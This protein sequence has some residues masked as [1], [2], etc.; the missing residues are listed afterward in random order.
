MWELFFDFFCSFLCRLNPLRY[1]A[2]QSDS[3]PPLSASLLTDWL[4]MSEIDPAE[5]A[6]LQRELEST[7][8]FLLD[9]G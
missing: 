4:G 8:Y 6:D 9:T 5:I 3:A 1:S 7:S 2:S